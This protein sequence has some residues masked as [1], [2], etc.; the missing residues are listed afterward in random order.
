M[1]YPR[2]TNMFGA[3]AVRQK[4]ERERREREE[5]GD[6]PGIEE[7]GRRGETSQV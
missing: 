2:L 4:R 3:T 7:G 1:F 5:R 6:Q